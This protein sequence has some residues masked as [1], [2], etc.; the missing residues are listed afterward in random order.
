MAEFEQIAIDIGQLE[1][2]ASDPLL[3]DSA[4]PLRQLILHLRS[5]LDRQFDMIAAD[6]RAYPWWEAQRYSP[7]KFEAGAS[8]SVKHPLG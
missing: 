7:A 8:Q 1:C 5:T 4:E 6:L 3:G 2:I